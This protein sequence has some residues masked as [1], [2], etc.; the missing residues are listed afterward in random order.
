[1]GIRAEGDREGTV[2][3]ELERS[4]VDCADDAF[5]VAPVGRAPIDR[6]RQVV[7]VTSS[8]GDHVGPPRIEG[9]VLVEGIGVVASPLAV[10]PDDVDE[11]GAIGVGPHVGV[12]S[13]R[14]NGEDPFVALENALGVERHLRELQPTLEG[15]QLV[16]ELVEG[17]RGQRRRRRLPGLWPVH[18]FNLRGGVVGGR[19]PPSPGRGQPSLRQGGG[20]DMCRSR[21]P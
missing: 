7:G 15:A 16:E 2:L 12:Q 20:P 6:Q 14:Q 1:M 13:H 17:S 18:R 19:L 5:G 3:V 8:T 4:V 21:V 11:A 10:R 9:G